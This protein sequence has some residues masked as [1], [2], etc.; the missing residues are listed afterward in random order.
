MAVGV[1]G[2]GYAIQRTIYAGCAI[3]AA[4]M[5]ARLL[6]WILCMMRERNKDTRCTAI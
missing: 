3:A 6:R 2:P 5:I 4:W 1:A